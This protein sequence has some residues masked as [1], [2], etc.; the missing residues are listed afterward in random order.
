VSDVIIFIA[1]NKC[2][3]TWNRKSLRGKNDTY[4]LKPFKN[5]KTVYSL[6]QVRGDV[7]GPL[8]AL[9]LTFEGGPRG[10][11]VSVQGSVLKI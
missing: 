11:R 9:K 7:H 6:I 8:N 10:S 3:F 5:R 4:L 1:M 2:S